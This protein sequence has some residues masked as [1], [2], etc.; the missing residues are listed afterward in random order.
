MG[1]RVKTKGSFK[2]MEKYLADVKKFDP[3]PILAKYGEMGVR[4]LSAATPVFTGRAA[5]SWYYE[6]VETD[7]GYELQYNN[8]DVENGLNVIFLIRQGHVNFSGGWVPANDF[9]T[10]IIKDLFKELSKELERRYS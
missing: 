6:I 3:I 5:S 4:R 7:E 1:V 10:P 8:R 2:Y 9:V